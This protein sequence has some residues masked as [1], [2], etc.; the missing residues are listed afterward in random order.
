MNL[1]I[2]PAPVRKSIVVK[3][4]IDKAFAVFTGSMGRWW[5]ATH[6][7][8]RASP[9]AE[10]IMEPSPQGRWYERGQD[11]SECQWGH[12]I[13]WEPPHRVLL[14]W[15][16]NGEWQ[17][18]PGL[19]TELE[20]RFTPQGAHATRVELEHRN[21][22]RLGDHAERARTAFDGEGGWAGLLAA[23]ADIAAR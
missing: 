14:A 4:G 12:V 8:N 10:V 3:T 6:S 7:T 17:F 5:P 2:L 22:E 23:Y 13:A 18:D 11:G 21:L 20:I 15:Q 16:L 9:L 1:Q 19:V